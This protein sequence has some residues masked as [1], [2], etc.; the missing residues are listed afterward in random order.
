[1]FFFDEFLILPLCLLIIRAF[2]RHE[3]W[4]QE[5][6]SILRSTFTR[7]HDQPLCYSVG[8]Q[9]ITQKAM[10]HLIVGIIVL[11]LF[12]YLLAAVIRPEKF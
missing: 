5:R 4:G 1:M 8:C 12:L 9:R 2:R 7:N 3:N 11:L 6:T 10:E